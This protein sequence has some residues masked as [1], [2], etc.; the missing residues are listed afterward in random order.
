MGSESFAGR[1]TLQARQFQTTTSELR[2]SI[3][4]FIRYVSFAL[5]PVGALLTYSQ[6]RADQSL[7][8]AIGER[9]PASSRWC[10]RAWCC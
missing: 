6:L 1:L 8:D 4:R 7:P 3:N 5:I 9:S 10:R 2:D